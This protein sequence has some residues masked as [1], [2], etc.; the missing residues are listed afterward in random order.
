MGPNHSGDV[1][2]RTMM[3][4]VAAAAATVV[5]SSPATA[6]TYPWCAQYED[7]TNC[8]FTSLLQCQQALSG[9]GG[10]C[11]QNPNF[12][13][14]PPLTTSSIPPGPSVRTTTGSALRAESRQRVTR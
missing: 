1:K 3:L 14:A 13:A 12:L 8:G 7:G 6:Q 4:T 5:L 11:D 10:F 9:N 2:M